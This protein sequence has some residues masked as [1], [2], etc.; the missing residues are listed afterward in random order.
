MTEE[1]TKLRE[2]LLQLGQ[3]VIIPA[4]EL[5]QPEDASDDPPRDITIYPVGA[6]NE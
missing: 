1:I 4:R 3:P 2:R 5:P 6:N